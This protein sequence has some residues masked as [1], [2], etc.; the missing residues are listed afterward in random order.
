VVNWYKQSVDEGAIP[1]TRQEVEAHLRSR[2]FD[3]QRFIW[4]YDEPTGTVTIRLYSADGKIIG[5]QEYRP[6]L[7]NKGRG[8]KPGE[9]K[10]YFNQLPGEMNKRLRVWGLETIDD[11][12]AYLFITEGIFDAAPITALG[13]P[14]I[15]AVGSDITP[16]LEQQLKFFH[17]N[18]IGILDRDAAGDPPKG[19]KYQTKIKHVVERLGGV[20]FVVPEPY[21]D[22]GEIYQDNPAKAKS[23]LEQIL[24]QNRY[25]SSL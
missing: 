1:L 16:E 19:R 20:S 22:F 24:M 25:F 21:K 13:E 3:P 10:R 11:N 4:D 17:K 7:T 14:A 6:H 18:L 15:A 5:T 8:D 2:G 9:D 23:F 12:K